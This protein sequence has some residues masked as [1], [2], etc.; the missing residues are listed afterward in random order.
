MRR[1][2]RRSCYERQREA[3]RL[4]KALEDTGIKLDCVATDIL[5]KSGRAM[6]DAL[7][8]G[9]SD[10]EIL[11]ELAKGLLRK[12]LPEL[13]EALRGRFEPHHALIIGAILSHLDF[14][15]EHINQ[16]SE[17]IE[18]ELGPTGQA[19]VTLAATI[20]GVQQ[21]T[22]EVMVAEIGTDM[23]AFPSAGHLAS[24]AG[25]C[26]GNDQSAGRRRCGRRRKGSKFLAIALQKAALAA[27]R[28]NGSYA[29]YQRLKPRIGHRRALGAVQHSML[30]A[31]WHM[32]TTGETYREPGGD[33]YQRRNPERLTKRLVARLGSLGHNVI[34]QP[35][36]QAA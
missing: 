35:Q 20:T 13:K 9:T 2:T 34:L 19:G 1:R 22:A 12:K 29:Q 4:H 14:L 15:D 10:P 16:L 17:A 24:W 23:S 6:L 18:A 27:T 3:N 31:Y 30:I 26:P 21:R 28:A 11:A 5:G 7:V 8:C 36:P 32:F 33:Y 25:R